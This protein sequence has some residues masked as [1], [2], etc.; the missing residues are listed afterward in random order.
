MRTFRNCLASSVKTKIM[1]LT[2]EKTQYLLVKGENVPHDTAAIVPVSKRLVEM[3]T[4]CNSIMNDFRGFEHCPSICYRN[5]IEAYFLQE[6]AM[7]LPFLKDWFISDQAFSY[8]NFT[9]EELLEFLQKYSIDSISEIATLHVTTAN[10]FY[11]EVDVLLDDE[12]Q[13]RLTY[14]TEAIAVTE[15]LSDH[16][17]R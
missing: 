17:Q 14:D 5:Y 7:E 3:L 12:E 2:K 6:E 11:W 8:V 16:V 9:E 15:L 13:I 1:N 4:R 10:F